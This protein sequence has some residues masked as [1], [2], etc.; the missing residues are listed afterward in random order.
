MSGLIFLVV[1]VE[2]VGSELFE[3][4]GGRSRQGCDDDA[5]Q[6]QEPVSVPELV[7][8]VGAGDAQQLG[9]ESAGDRPAAAQ[10]SRQEAV[11]VVQAAGLRMEIAAWT[12]EAPLEGC[13]GKGV[14]VRLRGCHQALKVEPWHA[15]Q[16]RIAEHLGQGGVDPSG[17]RRRLRGP[18]VEWAATRAIPPWPIARASLAR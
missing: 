18:A 13:L 16:G 14:P 6:V 8:E 9:Q 15:S 17:G 10:Q 12:V 1:L 3:G 5:V 2:Q 11:V 4:P 7:G